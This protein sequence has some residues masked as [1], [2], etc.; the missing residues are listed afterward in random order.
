MNKPF[1]KIKSILGDVFN[2]SSKL[3]EKDDDKNLD[4]ELDSIEKGGAEGN[5][6]TP[7]DDATDDAEGNADSSE[8]G[9][10]SDAVEDGEIDGGSSGGSDGGMGGMGGGFSGGS[11]DS[12]APADDA[13]DNTDKDEDKDEPPVKPNVTVQSDEQK[14]D[15]MFTDTGNMDFDYSL[16]NENNIRLSKFKFKK[17]NV[18][19]STMFAESEKETGVPADE[20][21]LR[22]APEQKMVYKKSNIELRKKYPKIDAREKNIIIYN[23]N[24]PFVKR[25]VAGNEVPLEENE[26]QDAYKKINQYMIKKYGQYWQDKHAAIDFITSIK[27]NFSSKNSIRPNLSYAKDLFPESDDHVALPFDSVTI[28]IPNDVDEFLRNN[29]E[30]EKFKKS[31]V[32]RT[33]ASVYL[34]QNT[35]S[36]GVYAI[37]TPDEE[38]E[39]PVDD[40]TDDSS[41]DDETGDTP[42]DFDELEDN[43]TDTSDE[44]EDIED[45][46]V[47][48]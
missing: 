48:I 19:Y 41:S 38:V 9:D 25:D 11:G 45:A 2:R 42:E 43:T 40:T 44:E 10:G 29:L 46:T 18:D 14:V 20:I 5:A 34:D 6:D 32:F 35:K 28:K 21:E 36:N 27:V 47:D 22:M 16:S 24:V 4:S 26:I 15:S 17:A 1:T 23:S 7:K 33:L 31:S 37:I 39:E 12:D 3:T 13:K 8:A 30:N